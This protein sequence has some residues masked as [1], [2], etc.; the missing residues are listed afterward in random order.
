MDGI[1][2]KVLMG[3]G[4]ED[5]RRAQASYTHSN[6]TLP[7]ASRVTLLIFRARNIFQ[8]LNQSGAA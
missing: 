8:G 2:K 3:F 1:G 5:D 4:M 6:E 7:K